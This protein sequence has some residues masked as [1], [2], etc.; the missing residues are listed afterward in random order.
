MADTYTWS[1]NTL[2]R[3]LSNGVV[4]TV[5][6]SVAASRRVKIEDIRLRRNEYHQS[7]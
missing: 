5:H 4:Y 6:W 2:D 7:C 1:V 3:E